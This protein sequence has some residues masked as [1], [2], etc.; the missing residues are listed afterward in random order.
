MAIDNTKEIRRAVDTGKVAFGYKQC[1]KE[2][3]KG[4]GEVVIIAQSMPTNE[5]EALKHLAEI[6]KKKVFD[7]AGTGHELGAVCGKPFVISSMVVLEAG[8]SLVKELA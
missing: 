2:M 1:R 5:K 4:N 7:Y 3:L 8:K 6:E